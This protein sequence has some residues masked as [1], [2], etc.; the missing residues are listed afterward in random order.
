MTTDDVLDS[1]LASEGS[2]YTNTPGDAGGPTRWGVTLKTLSAY[3]GVACT[4]EDV[5]NLTEAEARSIYTKLY[6]TPFASF[7]SDEL[8]LVAVDAAVLHGVAGSIVLLQKAAGVSPDGVLGPMTL[9]AVQR[10]DG[11]RL[12]LFALAER[13]SSEGGIVTHDP[14][15]A[16]FAAGWANR[17]NRLIRAVA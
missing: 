8:R 13:C 9:A 7:A 3:R 5:E 10:L 1:I 14:T 4:P 17:V 11:K 16:K 15:Q 12:A 6:V 2:T